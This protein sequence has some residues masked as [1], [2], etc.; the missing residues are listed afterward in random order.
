MSKFQ[1][2]LLYLYV[3]LTFFIGKSVRSWLNFD[4]PPTSIIGGI[5]YLGFPILLILFFTL[6]NKHFLK[7]EW[8]LIGFSV[9]T[10]MIEKVLNGSAVIVNIITNCFEPILL[11]IR[12]WD[13]DWY[14][15]ISLF[16]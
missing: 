16:Q 12:C 8:W 13:N 4:F 14:Q 15:Y 10:I 6:K 5:N 9:I 2:N 3:F 11:A 7:E 1:N